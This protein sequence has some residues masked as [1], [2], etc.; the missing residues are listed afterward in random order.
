VVA[1]IFLGKNQTF[2][3][4][5]FLYFDYR[6]LP[7]PTGA[8][9][10]RRNTTD[11]LA[12]I[13]EILS[14]PEDKDFAHDIITRICTSRFNE[15]NNHMGYLIDT[16]HPTCFLIK[17]YHLKPLSY[18][19]DIADLM[20]EKKIKSVILYFVREQQCNLQVEIWKWA[21]D[22]D[23]KITTPFQYKEHRT[24]ID[25]IVEKR[26]DQSFFSRDADLSKNIITHVY[27]MEEFLSTGLS[28][29]YEYSRKDETFKLHFVN[30]EKINGDFMFYLMNRFRLSIHD[31]V[32]YFDPG[33]PKM[34]LSIAKSSGGN[35][36]KRPYDDRYSSSSE[37]EYGEYGEYDEPPRRRSRKR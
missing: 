28:V 9:M 16:N 30:I 19:G 7:L 15:K 33:E 27:N 26:I 11:Q 8:P 23:Q 13:N 14:S 35:S 1:R 17:F 21:T 3:S 25:R 36:K 20:K 6:G 2:L 12:Y 4:I 10:E 31:V 32:F 18:Q 22:K 5:Y 34:V 29:S 24:G 37:G